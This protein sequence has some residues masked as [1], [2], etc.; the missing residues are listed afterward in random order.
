L[1]FNQIDYIDGRIFGDW[2]DSNTK[3]L[4]YLNL[5][6]NRITKFESSLYNLIHI[7]KLILTNNE[8]TNFPL[9]DFELNEESSSDI[10]LNFLYFNRNNIKSLTFFSSYFSNLRILDLNSNEISEI[11]KNAFE[12]L[13]SLQNLSLS[14]NL[15][16]NITREIFFNQMHLFYLNLSCNQIEFIEL[17]SFKSNRIA[18]T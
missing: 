3:S 4:K 10:N 8:L 7:E 13:K 17:N 16:K 18:G 9:F 1:S 15:L 2:G 14:N 5:E 12:T 11:E 6:S